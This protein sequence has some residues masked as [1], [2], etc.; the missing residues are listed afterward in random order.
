MAPSP[1]GEGGTL[2]KVTEETVGVDIDGAECAEGIPDR[3]DFS[4]FSNRD[5]SSSK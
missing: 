3:L 2:L 4:T 1:F 5:S